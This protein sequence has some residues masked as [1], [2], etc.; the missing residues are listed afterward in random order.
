M[1]VFEVDEAYAP[2]VARQLKPKALL[3]L[4][5]MRDQL[6]R[7]GEIDTTAKMIAKAA[8]YCDGVIINAGDPPLTDALKEVIATKKITCFSVA[9]NLRH[10]LP[11]D[12]ELISFGSN[13]NAVRRH[14]E[15]K[16]SVTLT[17]WQPNTSE[18][19]VK[20]GQK[21]FKTRLKFEGIHNAQNVTA[22]LAVMHHEFGELDDK[23]I[24]VL[25]E[26]SPA[27]GRGEQ[28]AIRGKK[29]H[30]ALIKNPSG[31]NQNIRAFARPNIGTVLLIINDRYADGRDVSWL[32]DVDIS[33]LAKLNS[34]Y[35]TSGTRA[36]D[37]ALRLEYED[38]RQIKVQTS[39]K[40]ALDY[41][42]ADTAE[43][44]DLLI[45]PTYTAMLEIRKL[46][47]KQTSMED[48]WQ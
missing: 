7:Y 43:D 19:E 27:F 10:F 30:I 37:M 2:L 3:A 18:V 33:A 40:R 13:I 23:D 11:S 12:K 20:V 6:D 22:A 8:T 16:P 41:A 29:V 4:N 9:D 25:A 28:L 21:K 14:G 35:V 5:V 39:I 24:A 48:I 45:M 26:I 36:Y 46:L 44:K 31:F 17:G 34:N 1:A 38:V 15:F 42:L 47:A 32:W